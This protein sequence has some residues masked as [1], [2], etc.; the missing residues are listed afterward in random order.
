[1]SQEITQPPKSRQGQ[2]RITT[3]KQRESARANGR[4]SRG[5]VTTDGK[6]RNRLNGFKHGA[7][8][9]SSLILPEDQK[10]FNAIFEDYI[11][12][13]KPATELEL[14]LIEQ[15][16]SASWRRRRH[17]AMLHH[18][19]NTAIS[20]LTL[21][22]GNDSLNPTAIA[23][24]AFEKLLAERAPL[25]AL[26]LAEQREGRKFG[27]A[28]RNFREEQKWREKLQN[29]LKPDFDLNLIP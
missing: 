25:H 28:S 2:R 13:Y 11:E 23:A 15:M 10:R 12:H 21:L 3:E 16:V 26:E 19:W 24:R 22:P 27:N 20:D 7:Y 29:N 18:I 9:Q 17:A 4:K 6:H 1:M 8:S 5:P 14:E